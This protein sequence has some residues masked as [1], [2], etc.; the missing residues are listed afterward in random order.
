MSGAASLSDAFAEL[1]AAFEENHPDTDVILNLAGSSALREQILA[2]APVDVFAS[3]NLGNMDMVVESGVVRGDSEVF[4]LN[5]LAIAVPTDNPAGITGLDD[6]AD[7]DLLIGLCAPAVPC[8]D[9]ARQALASAGVEPVPDTNESDVRALLVKVE[10]GELD[11]GIVYSTD[12]AAR[13]GS[14]DGIEIPD[15]F[16]V[17]AEYPIAVLAGGANTE[18]AAL[19]VEFVLSGAG[20]SILADHGFGSP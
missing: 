2:G 13:R 17:T 11:A 5:R 3:A 6:F 19:F 7:S 18:D 4:A 16:N 10:A 14:V 1:E 12:V 15:Q 20:R 8:G 9:F